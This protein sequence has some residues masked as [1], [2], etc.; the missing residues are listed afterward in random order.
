[1]ELASRPW[2][3]RRRWGPEP[4]NLLQILP[5]NG[6]FRQRGGRGGAQTALTPF[7]MP[8][9]SASDYP[10]H[11]GTDIS[12][13]T[14]MI[15]NRSSCAGSIISLM[16]SQQSSE[17]GRHWDQCC[18][19]RRVLFSD[20]SVVGHEAS[21]PSSGVIGTSAASS[22][23][24]SGVAPPQSLLSPGERRWRWGFLPFP[25]DEAGPVSVERLCPP[26]GQA[27]RGTPCWLKRVFFPPSR[28]VQRG[29][30]RI[31]RRGHRLPSTPPVRYVR[32]GAGPGH[33]FIAPPDV[34]LVPQ[35]SG[36]GVFKPH[37]LVS[38]FVI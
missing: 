5:Q 22:S 26:T 9:V 17:R 2:K 13:L 19:L 8:T 27:S 31:N 24:F 35:R 4:W 30:R 33:A 25:Q 36:R 32:A 37:L 14:S 6:K 11:F 18:R 20:I 29:D 15:P 28:M 23:E 38:P 21:I 34:A 3:A 1:M 12:V 7:S 10:P 16:T